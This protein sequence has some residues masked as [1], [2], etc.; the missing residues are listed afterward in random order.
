MDRRR[1]SPIVGTTNGYCGAMIG[2]G[3]TCLDDEGGYKTME[4]RGFVLQHLRRPTTINP[5]TTYQQP[6]TRMSLQ[7]KRTFVL[8][9]GRGLLTRPRGPRPSNQTNGMGPYP[10]AAQVG[11]VRIGFLGYPIDFPLRSPI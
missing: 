2:K 5:T 3:D 9:M 4:G 7:N 6:S 10:N 11:E 8:P 1:I